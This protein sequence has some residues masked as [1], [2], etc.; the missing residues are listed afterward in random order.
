VFDVIEQK[1]SLGWWVVCMSMPPMILKM[2]I[3]SVLY[4]WWVLNNHC[5]VQCWLPVKL[6]IISQNSNKMSFFWL[7][8]VEPDD[9][10]KRA[11]FGLN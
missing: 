6:F 3:P 9:Q 8:V 5:T 2:I 11:P 1:A 7:L 10:K 4:S